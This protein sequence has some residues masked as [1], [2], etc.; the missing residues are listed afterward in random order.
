MQLAELKRCLFI[1]G[2]PTPTASENE[3]SFVNFSPFFRCIAALRNGKKGEKWRKR[4]ILDQVTPSQTSSKRRGTCFIS[5]TATYGGE[6]KFCRKGLLR[7][8]SAQIQPTNIGADGSHQQKSP[9]HLFVHGASFYSST[10]CN[11]YFVYP[12]THYFVLRA[13]C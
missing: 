10:E 2:S 9:A 8:L 6:K 13:V 5:Q 7:W 4:A 12:H 1:S 3:Q 11:S